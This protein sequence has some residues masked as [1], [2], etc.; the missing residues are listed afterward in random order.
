MIH[1]GTWNS[2]W[3]KPG[4]AKGG[5]V[6]NLLT[7]PDC[8]ILCVTEGYAK[9]LPEGGHTIDAGPC[10]GCPILEGQRKVLLWSKRQWS[11]VDYDKTGRPLGGR[12]VTGIT[13]TEAGPLQVVGVCIPWHGAHVNY[14]QKDSKYWQ[15]H[16]RWLAAFETLRYRWARART[17][18]LGDYNQR[19][20]RNGKGAPPVRTHELLLRAFDGFEIAT[21]GELANAPAPGRAIDHIAHTPDLALVGDIEFWP[22]NDND[23]ELSDHFGIRANFDFL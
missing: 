10:W 6:A 12:F 8:D 22:K 4:T 7:E 11:E 2:K 13:E 20:P 16:E 15:E 14:C 21:D 23:G 18:V 5:R 9:I 17:V 19:I 1:I 3:A